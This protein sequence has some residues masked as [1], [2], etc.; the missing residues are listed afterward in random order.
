MQPNTRAVT[1]QGVINIPCHLS[2]LDLEFTTRDELLVFLGRSELNLGKLA[3]QLVGEAEGN[4]G[5]RTALGVNRDAPLRPY[6][7]AVTC[8]RFIG[9]S[10]HLKAINIGGNSLIGGLR[11]EMSPHLDRASTYSE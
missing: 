9:Y 10:T 11:R 8:K 4:V 6:E 2:E 7:I 5:A 3:H 1:V